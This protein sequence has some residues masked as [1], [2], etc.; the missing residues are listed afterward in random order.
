MELRLEGLLRKQAAVQVHEYLRRELGEADEID[1]RASY[2]LKD[3]FDCRVCAGHIMQVY[4]KGIM[5]ACESEGGLL[6][7]GTERE[8]SGK[9]AE[10]IIEKVFC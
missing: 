6:I 2:E 10:K 7:F 4:V 9:E 3:L 8:I 1:V 5:E